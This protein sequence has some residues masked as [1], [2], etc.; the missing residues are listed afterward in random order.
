MNDFFRICEW[1]M[2]VSLSDERNVNGIC[3]TKEMHMNTQLSLILL[4]QYF[5]PL[6]P[7][8]H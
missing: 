4:V 8:V 2:L 1:N 5:K 7:G 6:V 3:R